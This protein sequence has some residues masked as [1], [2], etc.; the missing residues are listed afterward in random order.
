MDFDRLFKQSDA[1]S[2]DVVEVIA[3]PP[4]DDSARL[5]VS[6]L[7]CSL[8]I[9]HAEAARALLQGGLLP[10][11]LV[12]HRA[13][14]ETVLRSIWAL[15]G[16]SDSQ[17]EKLAADLSVDSEQAAKNLPSTNTI[18]DELARK[19]PANAYAPLHEF[20]EYNWRAL[21]SY[22][23]AGIHPIR[24]HQEGYPIGLIVNAL[25]NVNGLLVIA[26]M[27]AAILTGVPGLQQK[28][29]DAAARYGDVLRPRGAEPVG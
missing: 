5:E 7:L 9:E 12:I 4:F 3:L 27:Q 10:S 18:M 20:K 2:V 25:F 14:F 22:A 29:L 6:G 26:A 15:Y 24:R 21:N 19:A 28:V 17:I 1:L 16:A 13:Q 8:A 11:A 23:H